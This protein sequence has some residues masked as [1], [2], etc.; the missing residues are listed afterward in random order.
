MNEYETLEI[1]Q[2][3]SGKM[4]SFK[5]DSFVFNGDATDVYIHCNVTVCDSTQENCVKVGPC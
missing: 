4:A 1:L 3:G 2:N 5:I